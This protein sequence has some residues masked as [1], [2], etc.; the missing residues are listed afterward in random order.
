MGDLYNMVKRW[1]IYDIADELADLVPMM[2]RVIQ[3]N[4]AIGESW[5]EIFKFVKGLEKRLWV[6]A[7]RG[8]QVASYPEYRSV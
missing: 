2:T 4:S 6:A 3:G 1:D 5:E 8:G 7:E